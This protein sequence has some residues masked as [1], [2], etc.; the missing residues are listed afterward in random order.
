MMFL[1]QLKK[2]LERNLKMKKFEKWW[3]KQ[4]SQELTEEFLIEN[5]L[6]TQEQ[7]VDLLAKTAWQAALEEVLGWLD[8]SFE[9]KEIK[10]KIHDELES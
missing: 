5:K 1:W 3:N 9:H 8:Y 6:T 7:V 10:D 2:K 4:Q